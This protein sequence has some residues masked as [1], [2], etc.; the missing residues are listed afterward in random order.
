MINRR[1]FNYLSLKNFLL[2]IIIVIFTV[3]SLIIYVDLR[4]VNGLKLAI[5][6]FSILLF[7]L[8]NLETIMLKSKYYS[9][10]YN[11]SKIVG[12]FYYICFSAIIFKYLISFYEN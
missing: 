5:I 8:F 12:F 11:I 10:Y 6:L 4:Q 3:I 1:K 9:L 7:I 2:S